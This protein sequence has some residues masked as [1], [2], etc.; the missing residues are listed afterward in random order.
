MTVLKINHLNFTATLN[1]FGMAGKFEYSKNLVNLNDHLTEMWISSKINPPLLQ[2][3]EDGEEWPSGLLAL[4]RSE[5]PISRL[6]LWFDELFCC[7]LCCWRRLAW[8]LRSTEPLAERLTG[9]LLIW[10][11]VRFVESSLEYVSPWRV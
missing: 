4:F 6:L 5:F 1:F 7:N 9:G 8:L 3:E 11:M 10:K 2:V